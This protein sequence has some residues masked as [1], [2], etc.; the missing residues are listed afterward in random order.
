MKTLLIIVSFLIA[1]RSFAQSTTEGQ[2]KALSQKRVDWLLAGNLD[3]LKNLYDANSITIHGNGMMRGRQ[4]HLDDIK[5]G[6]PIYKKIDLTQST[7]KDFGDTAVLVGKGVFQ[8]AMNGQNMTYNMTFTEVYK[9]EK[10]GWKLIARQAVDQ[11]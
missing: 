11:K 3:S 5:S 4:E 9:K 8:I 1:T 10:A 7:V 2:L 6:R